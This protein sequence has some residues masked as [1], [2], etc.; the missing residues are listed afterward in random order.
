MSITKKVTIKYYNIEAA[1]SDYFDKLSEFLPEAL[2]NAAT[3]TFE[4]GESKYAWEVIE[5]I[6]LD[7]ADHYLMS[8]TKEKAL[9]PV[10]TKDDGA[11]AELSL[12][13]GS[14]GDRSY[15]LVSPKYKIIITMGSQ[16]L[17]KK[18]LGQF[19]TEGVVRLNPFYEQG[20][21][22]RVM[23]WDAYKKISLRLNMPSEND[24]M[25][26]HETPTGELMLILGHLGGMKLDVSVSAGGGR[27]L[28]SNMMV[29]NLLPE[30]LAND[31]CTS[32]TVRGSDFENGAPEQFD[33][34]N[35]QIKYTE[36][37]EVEGRYI[38]PADAK[39][40]LMRA[41]N[42]HCKILIASV[43]A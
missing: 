19:S 15:C 13:D 33:L 29:K 5:K 40:I 27:E 37:V 17:F 9:Y 31:L 6:E 21:D 43:Q 1:E 8:A 22:E 26:F 25:D 38:T 11:V 12:P 2:E 3:G 18:M 28:L 30:L 34:K 24:V 4:S 16:G 41:T 7:A 14:L 36:T 10:W 23:N 20:I 32:L 39:Q 42:A 35:A